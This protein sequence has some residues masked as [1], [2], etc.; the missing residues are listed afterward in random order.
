[1]CLCVCRVP[2][3]ACN[4]WRQSSPKLW[5]RW[6]P[7]IFIT[8]R[9][10]QPSCR[11]WPLTSSAD[12]PPSDAVKRCKISGFVLIPP[13]LFTT[14]AVSKTQTRILNATRV[15]V[16]LIKCFFPPFKA[17]DQMSWLH[18]S[19]F[20][21]ALEKQD[22]SLSPKSWSRRTFCLDLRPILS[23]TV[24]L[25]VC[26]RI[27][28]F[29]WRKERRLMQSSCV[30]FPSFVSWKVFL[31]VFYLRPPESFIF[32][33]RGN[34]IRF[35][36]K[37]LKISRGALKPLIRCLGE[38]WQPSLSFTAVKAFKFKVT[39]RCSRQRNICI[40]IVF[41]LISTLASEFD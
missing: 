13:T 4:S 6:F 3:E 35:K 7:F 22:I 20:T 33:T 8:R 27:K 28:V 23:P 37:F 5:E 17:K 18:T 32:I 12:K 14:P 39:N 29:T 36:L 15:Y 30:I 10:S 1:M 41:N 2:M 34:W 31:R 38:M 26:T 21:P 9:A 19:P 24:P 16:C 25:V 40:W 11:P